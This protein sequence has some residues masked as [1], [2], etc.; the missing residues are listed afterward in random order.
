M[1]ICLGASLVVAYAL[2]GGCGA[3]DPCEDK[4]CGDPCT[5]CDPDD[6]SCVETAETK[7]C[8]QNQ[9]CVS[10]QPPVCD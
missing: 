4:S 8:N 3:Y 9:V 7:V 5:V 1:R 2:A 6:A 10:A